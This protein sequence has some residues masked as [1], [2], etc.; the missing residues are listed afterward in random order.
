MQKPLLKF[1]KDTLPSIAGACLRATRALDYTGDCTHIKMRC[2]S[3]ADALSLSDII[4][5][6]MKELDMPIEVSVSKEPQHML[7]VVE[8]K[9]TKPFPEEP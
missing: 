7:C 4:A 8:L 5:R 1:H 2:G 3:S 9:T 6:R